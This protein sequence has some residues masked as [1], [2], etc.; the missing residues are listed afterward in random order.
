MNPLE[1]PKI[2]KMLE[3]LDPTVRPYAE[4]TILAYWA[5]GQQSVD[6]LIGV[7]ANQVEFSKMSLSEL[8]D[9]LKASNDAS[10]KLHVQTIELKQKQAAFLQQIAMSFVFML[11]R[12]GEQ[13][14]VF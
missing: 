1:L 5:L 8:T 7:V 6:A 2:K 3:G 4:S 9:A 11:L 14:S 10:D 12:G 13:E